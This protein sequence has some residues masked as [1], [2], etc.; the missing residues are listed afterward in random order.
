VQLVIA[1]TSPINYL[2]EIGHIDLLS[3]LFERVA[4]PR[5]VQAVAQPP[6]D[7]LS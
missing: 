6:R 3:R 5:A 4:L 1:D 2:I 7:A